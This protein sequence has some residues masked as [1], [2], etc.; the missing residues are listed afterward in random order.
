MSESKDKLHIVI[1]GGGFAGLNLAK[2][3][4]KSHFEV[5]IIDRNNFH[6]FP[7]LFYQ[8]A[9]SGLDSASISFP[10]RRELRGRKSRGCR[11][12][13]GEVKSIDVSRKVVRTTFEEIPYD[14]LVIAAGTTNNFYGNPELAN[15]V[16]A[17]KSTQEA[18]RLRNGIISRFE[19]AALEHDVE[20]RRKML[21]FVVIG[22]GP[23]G[24]EI[25]GALGEMKRY[26]CP[27][28]YPEIPA[29]DVTVNIIEGTDRLLRTMSEK[30]SADALRDL[31]SLM[32]SVKLNHIMKSYSDN[33]VYLE[34]GTTIYSEMVIWTAGVSGEP[35]E[36]N[37]IDGFSRSKGDRIPTDEFCRVTGADD[38]YAIGD[39]G[40]VATEEYPH[41]YPQLAQVAIQQ[42]Q[43]V[44]EQINSGKATKPFRYTDKGSMATIGRNR[45]VADLGKIH[46]GGWIAW[47]AWMMVH[48]ISLLGMRNKLNVLIN[49]MWSY[50][51]YN[52]SL[53]LLLRPSRLPDRNPEH[54]P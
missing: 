54:L 44:A 4:D 7:P 46:L 22:G 24:V 32:V 48:L 37:G 1:I 21:S 33:T 40:F 11:F 23:A 43:Y 19:R 15:K 34:D 16:Y 42:G 9:S 27:R 53:R 45:A 25:A 50:F 18:I 51:T 8:V 49:W 12:H 14:K 10:L 47:M 41:G 13:I 31:D 5:S 30:A 6:G 17:L 20:K 3:L 26:V 29:E 38:V 28:D 52:S 2:R 36:I 35:F 39:I